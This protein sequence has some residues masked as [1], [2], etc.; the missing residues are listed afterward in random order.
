VTW[1]Q[2]GFYSEIIIVC[3][4]EIKNDQILASKLEECMEKLS[5][6]NIEY[7]MTNDNLG[8]IPK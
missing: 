5:L 4:I 6:L 7:V 3:F 2:N 1:L 8:S